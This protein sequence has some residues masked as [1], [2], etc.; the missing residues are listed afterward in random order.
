[1]MN[2]ELTAW[3]E[4]AALPPLPVRV[5]E[6]A[7]DRYW[8]GAGIEPAAR[9]AGLLYPPMAANL[10]ILAVQQV[11]DEPLLHTAQRLRCHRALLAPADLVVRGRCAR[12]FE[13]RGRSY[14]VVEA[15]IDG[16]DGGP[17]WTSIATFTP[18]RA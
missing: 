14:A 7:N 10:T 13:K 6:A 12:R 5:G 17:L 4:G 9:P 18:V 2:R 16:P 11:V 1:M 8:A 3:A 15:E